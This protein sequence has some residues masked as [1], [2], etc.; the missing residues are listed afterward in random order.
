M[1]AYDVRS[2][3]AWRNT[4]HNHVLLLT[5]LPLLLFDCLEPLVATLAHASNVGLLSAGDPI[6]SLLRGPQS[7][8]I[9]RRQ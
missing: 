3:V 8:W 1:D 9:A 2:G 5:S 7:R 6:R 4:K